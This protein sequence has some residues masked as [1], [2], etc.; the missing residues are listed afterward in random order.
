MKQNPL[1]RVE[2]F[3]KKCNI[4]IQEKGAVGLLLR[5]GKKIN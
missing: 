3:V 1:Y 5:V 4:N 2:V